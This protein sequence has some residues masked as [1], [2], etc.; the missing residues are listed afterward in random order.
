MEWQQII[1]FVHLIRL[2]SFTKAAEATFRTQS[3]LS[4]QIKALEEELGCALVER[5]GRRRIRLTEEGERFYRFSCSVLEQKHELLDDLDEMKSVYR[6]RMS[7]A[8]PFT[9][10]FHLLPPIVKKYNQNFPQVKLRLF[11][12][13]WRLASRLVRNGEVDFG[14]CL[15]SEAPEDL[16][17]I[18]W[19]PLQ[20][21]VLVPMEHPLSKT[22][23]V[24]FR[25]MAEYPLIL[26]PKELRYPIRVKFDEYL[27]RE[28]LSC[29]VLLESSN[30][31]LNAAYVEKG[32]G[33]SFATTVKDRPLR[34]RWNLNMIALDEYFPPEFLLVT[35][36]RDIRLPFYKQAFLDHLFDIPGARETTATPIPTAIE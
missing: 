17:S 34:G 16:N 27:A 36:R 7:M 26:P 21:M 30:V 15:E 35:M 2:G 13:S 12:Q 6:G 20:T 9:T 8:A 10:L 33:I 4:Q 1:G 11:D 3:A 19:L 14:V 23:R 28:N 24:T 22:T 29:H 25:E 18:R 5:I 31:E 32:L